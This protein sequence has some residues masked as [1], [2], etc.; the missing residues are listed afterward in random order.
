MSPF[1]LILDS[2]INTISMKGMRI[3]IFY[4]VL[5]CFFSV[6][7]MLAQSQNQQVKNLINQS[8]SL[9]YKEPNEAL[10]LATEAF[11]LAKKSNDL[12][13]MGISKMI[14]AEVYSKKGMAFNLYWHSREALGYLEESDTLDLF[15]VYQ[16]N[17]NL[18]VFFGNVGKYKEAIQHLEVANEYIEKLL[19]VQ[20]PDTTAKY[21]DDLLPDDIL[22]HMS[23]YYRRDKN[24]DKA[25]ELLVPLTSKKSQ[26]RNPKIYARSKNQLGLSYHHF[27][28]FEK[29]SEFFSDILKISVI[30]E[31]ERA[32]YFHNL[33]NSLSKLNRFDIALAYMDS[34]IAINTKLKR[35]KQIF[36][37]Y[38]DR[39]EILM[40][41]GDSFNALLSLDMAMNS[42]DKFEEDPELFKVFRLKERA[43]Y[44]IG[45]SKSAIVHGLKFDALNDMVHKKLSEVEFNEKALAFDK[46]LMEIEAKRE[47]QENME[48]A[49]YRALPFIF[50]GLAFV[51]CLIWFLFDRSKK[52]KQ[53]DKRILKKIAETGI[54][55]GF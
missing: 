13:S 53:S 27:G 50:L 34:S 49:F 35:A 32:Y 26:A 20:H 28:D 37:N 5:V 6:N 23:R 18:S 9:I 48:R 29:A 25:N 10:R 40:D 43:F 54:K 15:N 33:S 47:Q 19:V 36:I 30:S 8:N 31:S 22:Y 45:D 12:Y 55:R 39:G 4:C 14:A 1:L 24:I 42:Y 41:S 46:Q 44:S 21:K 51:V 2:K 17:K 52:Q 16:I 7:L 3:N 38:M 11:D